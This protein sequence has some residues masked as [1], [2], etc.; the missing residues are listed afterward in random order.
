MINPKTSI[1]QHSAILMHNYDN[2]SATHCNVANNFSSWVKNVEINERAERDLEITA[3][4]PQNFEGFAWLHWDISWVA[5]AIQWT[6]MAAR[7]THNLTLWVSINGL[8]VPY[9]FAATTAAM[10][11][12]RYPKTFRYGIEEMNFHFCKTISIHSW[13]G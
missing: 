6:I 8:V 5:Y 10:V 7:N 3:I 1:H 4:R 11:G 12:F 13:R 9:I 2:S